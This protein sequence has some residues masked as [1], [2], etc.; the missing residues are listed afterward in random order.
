[1]IRSK[2]RVG[3]RNS[4]GREVAYVS[5]VYGSPLQEPSSK[6]LDLT[7]LE[8]GI[9][10]RY[11]EENVSLQLTRD[12]SKVTCT[13][14]AS[15]LVHMYREEY[16]NKYVSEELISNICI[17]RTL[18]VSVKVLDKAI[19]TVYYRA[20]I[21]AL[22]YLLD[23]VV[24]SYASCRGIPLI[25]ECESLMA[26]STQEHKEWTESIQ[27]SFVINITDADEQCNSSSGYNAAVSQLMFTSAGKVLAALD[28]N[29]D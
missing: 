18:E 25:Q 12:E 11:L 27:S 22:Q 3:T 19:G 1:M 13:D 24:K 8:N 4:E 14:V 29:L 20:I 2:V 23:F 5:V 26:E 6:T 15:Y 21:H 28:A 17:G 7:K 9:L 10:S 16:L